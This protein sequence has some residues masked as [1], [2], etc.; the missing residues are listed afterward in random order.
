MNELAAAP[1][2]RRGVP[3]TRSFLRD[4]SARGG[5]GL[6]SSGPALR[7][8]HG[9]RTNQVAWYENPV[10]SGILGA[11]A[12]A[13]VTSAVSVFIWR[14]THKVK[15]IDCVVDDVSS[16]LAFSE[17]IQDRLEVK[18]AGNEAK[19]VYLISLEIANTGTEAVAAQPVHVRLA[20]GA[21]IVDYT[22]KT[23]PAVGFGDVAEKYKNGPALDLE[24]ALLNPRDRV[25]I[26]IVS[27]DN[28]SEQVDVYMKN[29]N[30]QSRVYTRKSAER[31]FQSAFA[32]KEMLVLAGL[33]AIPVFGGMARS[34]MT[35]ALAR[36]LDKVSRKDLG[37]P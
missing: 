13:V 5:R 1:R 15:R 22:V 21:R 11:L 30:V 31:V 28:T 29:A 2:A 27:I 14:R 20:D 35:L 9:K 23:D 37:T 34:L 33:S 10:V 24:I 16:L 12:G 4:T 17:Q 18:F 26:E 19:S 7:R 25:S 32:D 6:Q 36:K 8:R 3:H